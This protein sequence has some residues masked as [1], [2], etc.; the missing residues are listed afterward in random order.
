MHR[1][2]E[3]LYEV[4]VKLAMNLNILWVRN[5]PSNLIAIP[6]PWHTASERTEFLLEGLRMPNL[7]DLS[8][9]LRT[10]SNENLYSSQLVFTKENSSNGS[11]IKL[12]DVLSGPLSDL[13]LVNADLDC[14]SSGVGAGSDRQLGNDL[15]FL[16]VSFLIGGAKVHGLHGMD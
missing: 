9:L 4:L 6:K 15:R 12:I 5:I 11:Y 1:C 8:A 7:E 3:T 13:V 14:L 2:S 16:H 10:I